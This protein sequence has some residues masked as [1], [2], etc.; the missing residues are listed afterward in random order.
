MCEIA[1]PIEAPNVYH[2]YNPIPEK[3]Y[4]LIREG[5]TFPLS[6]MGLSLPGISTG[7]ARAWQETGQTGYSGKDVLLRPMGKIEEARNSYFDS[8]GEPLFYKFSRLSS[9]QDIVQFASE[10]GALRWIYQRAQGVMDS[11]PADIPLEPLSLW[12]REVEEMRR[13]L[14]AQGDFED[15][16]PDL[17]K[18]F[19]RQ[20]KTAFFLGASVD[21]RPEWSRGDIMHRLLIELFN[22]RL[23]GCRVRQ[24]YALKNEDTGNVVSVLYPGDLLSSMWIHAAQSFFHDGPNERIAVRSYLTGR[25][26][27]R[28]KMSRKQDEPFMGRYYLRGEYAAFKGR[29]KTGLRAK[30]K[31]VGLRNR[32]GKI[33]F[34]NTPYGAREESL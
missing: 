25:F 27:R 18:H 1:V 7:K 13:L 19:K 26:F 12:F 28:D 24:R 10:Y 20:G 3:G 21:I 6:T 9:E 32:S 11:E 17:D 22:K 4:S 2:F 14:A 16:R 5:E 29:E 33:E 30:E 34:I 23:E 8:E 31:G 15:K